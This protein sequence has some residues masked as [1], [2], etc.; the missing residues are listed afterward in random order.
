MINISR[1]TEKRKSWNHGKKIILSHPPL[2]KL[3][4]LRVSGVIKYHSP[5]KKCGL[6][7]FK[8]KTE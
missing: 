4:I 5:Q 7:S 2:N 8:I 3:L 1:D 6:Q